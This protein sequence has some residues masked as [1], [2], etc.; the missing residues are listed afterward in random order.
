[1]SRIVTIPKVL[2]GGYEAVAVGLLRDYFGL[3]DGVPYTGASFELLGHAWNDPARL[4]VI[5]ASDL[6]ALTT[7]SVPRSARTLADAAIELLDPM[8]SAEV[9]GLLAQIDPELHLVDAQDSEI[10]DD[11]PVSRLWARFRVLSD[12]GPVATSKLIAR[13]R[14]RLAPIYDSVV[15]A[16][17]GLKSSRGIYAGLRDALAAD[18][19]RLHQHAVSLHSQAE[20]P[21]E[22]APLRVIDVVVWMAGREPVKTHEIARRHG[23]TF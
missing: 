19:K 9:S 10:D 21:A 17:Y 6:L 18:G 4:D 1:M 16:E 22:V 13:K 5:T 8:V 15:G 7:L 20:L 2:H 14:P 11:A 12:F 23:L 3:D